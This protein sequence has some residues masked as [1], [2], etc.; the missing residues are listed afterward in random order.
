M[1]G[2]VLGEHIF[3]DEELGESYRVCLLKC[4]SCAAAIVSMQDQVSFDEEN[5][6]SSPR[7]V[8][9][10]PPYEASW[11]FPDLVREALGEADK[12]LRAGAYSASAVMSGKAIEG[13]CVHFKTKQAN[14]VDRLKE[15]Q[16]SGIIDSRLFQWSEEL[17]LHRNIGAHAKPEKITLEAAHNLF[18]FAVAICE[19]VFVLTEKFNAFMK[20]KNEKEHSG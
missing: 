15:L 5:P 19:Y 6:W 14:L 7:R 2:E 17:R 9:P 4:P 3:H 12:C 1:D 18:D 11:K 13:I 20:R 8:W 16:E 10:L